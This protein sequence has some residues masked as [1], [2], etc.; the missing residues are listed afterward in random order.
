MSGW[1]VVLDADGRSHAELTSG[2]ET[3]EKLHTDPAGCMELLSKGREGCRV[4]S[5]PKKGELW[6][7]SVESKKTVGNGEVDVF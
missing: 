7:F 4:L 5:V 2:V 1:R 3:L 6:E